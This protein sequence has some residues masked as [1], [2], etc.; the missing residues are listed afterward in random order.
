MRRSHS[1]L[2]A[3][4]L[5]V[6]FVPLVLSA[7]TYIVPSDAE[8]IRSADSIGIVHIRSSHSYRTDAGTIATDYIATVERSLKPMP[9]MGATITIT[10][11]GG[12]V[13][14]YGYGVSGEPAFI[15]GERTL[16]FLRRLHVG[17]FTTLDGE[18][19]KFNFVTDASERSLLIR[20]ASDGVYGWNAAG[21]QHVERSRDADKFVRYIEDVV[22][23]RQATVDYFVEF[24]RAPIRSNSHVAATDYSIL[25][26]TGV[27]IRW[28]SGGFSTQSTNE[29][30]G[31]T[32]L[33]GAIGNSRGA[34]NNAG[35]ASINIEYSGGG[36]SGTY[37]DLDFEN[38]LFFEQPNSGPLAGSVVGQ[39][40]FWYT[41]SDHTYNGAPFRDVIDCDVIIEA[42]LTGSLFEAVFGHELGHCLGFRHSNQP[43]AG[44]TTNTSD[45]LMNSSSS[46]NPALRPWDEDAASHVYGSGG[47]GGCTPPSIGSHPGSTTITQ[48]NST[49][50]TVSATGTALAYQ[51]YIGTNPDTSQPT[52]T[53]SASLL[54][55]PSSTTSYWV[56]VTGQCGTADSNTATVTVNP[57]ACTPPSINTHPS[58]ITINEGTGTTLSVAAA[59]TA[60]LSYQW[61]IGTSP[62]TS[63]PTGT[64]SFSLF[65]NPSS[66][67][68]YWVRVFGQCD[69]PADSTTATVTV[70]PAP[71][72]PPAINGHPQSVSIFEG[73]STAL[74]VS[75]SG[76]GLT[77]QWY[78]GNSGN[79]SQPTAT[80][81]NTISVSPT[82]TTSYWVRVSGACG[83]PVDSNT[84]TVTVTP[85]PEVLVGT[86]I[87]TKQPNGSYV[88]TVIADSDG[89]PL[90]FQWFRG[91]TPGTGGTFLGTGSSM[92]VPA[93]TGPTSY[94]VRV[95]NNCNKSAVSPLVTISTC[96][97]PVISTQPAD[98]S[99]A[100][101]GSANLSVA[102]TP[103]AGATVRWYRGTAPDKSNE[104]G[105]G[106]TFN[107]GPLTTTTSFFA[108]IT[109]PS[110][111][112]T[113]VLTRTAIVSISCTAPSV[114]QPP[115]ETVTKGKPATITVVATG[116]GPLTYQWYQGALGVVLFPV[117][118]SSATLV[119]AP[120]TS[121]TQF[122]VLV[123]NACG[124]A[125]TQ[126]IEVKV[127]IPKRRSARH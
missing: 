107:T 74:F 39:A 53:N 116:S 77:Y 69:S 110:C 97:L 21:Q 47:G 18:L 52:G 44:Q 38:L 51:W 55:S 75:A 100:S 1:R 126:N 20:G 124:E 80:N 32:D 3:V 33:A 112:D 59:G 87:A 90:S 113:V 46:G 14:E 7:A 8:M 57:P 95:S 9:R 85:C 93:P 25:A 16:L 105:T 96:E 37:G 86:P 78:I 98:Q 5:F 109:I 12:S 94:W 106:T 4:S 127:N 49:T 119:T 88:L 31:V 10:Q 123:K 58:S 108:S 6:L 125:F 81:S 42:G 17:H 19:G 15:V 40:S 41:N 115:N 118:T 23:D 24:A 72:V 79:T 91:T 92:A 36:G 35:D 89:L 11:K 45:A 82:T 76:S 66:T 61:Y 50:L 111:P 117:G 56:R 54:V 28:Q 34:W 63:Q 101:G 43:G 99:I 13:G 84:A 65:V 64:D 102:F 104:V 22:A 120:L 27:G 67:T 122:W 103:A 83:T 68:S 71:C 48:G 70:N 2:T 60:P 121:A 29:Q 114:T 30:T 26:A 73:Q 62:N